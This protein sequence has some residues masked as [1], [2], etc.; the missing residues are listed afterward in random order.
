M[1][2]LTVGTRDDPLAER[3]PPASAE[4]E[5]SVLGCL[6]QDNSAIAVVS[7]LIDAR[8]FYQVDHREIFA[9][10][11]ALLQEGRP[12]DVVT[13]FERLQARGLGDECGGLQ[14][15]TDLTLCVPSARNAR[16]YAEIVAERF[17]ERALIAGCDEAMRISQDGSV[18]LADRVDSIA[19]AMARAEALRKGPARRVPLLGL[20]ALRAQSESVRWCVKHVLPAAS[21]GMLFG[22]SGTFKSFIA[23]D[24]ALHIVHGLPWMGRI[25]QT[26]PV[27]YIAAEGG[28][29]LWGRVDA[30][31]RARNLS[32]E[33]APLYV[34]P[35]AI[36]LTVDA[37]RV[38][39]AAQTVGVCPA[40]VVVDTLSQTYA[41]EENSANEMAAYLREIGLRFRALWGCTVLLVHHTGHQ[42]TERPRGSSAI[43]ANID[44]L[45]GVQR[46][47]KEMLATVSCQKQKDGDLFKDAT[48]SL[49]VVGLG[50]DA[51][52]DDVTSLVARQLGT[53]DEVQQ[54]R[55]AEQQAGRG[56]RNQILMG[57]VQN[58]MEERGL[59]KA[60]YEDLR[61]AG[62][63]DGDALKKAYYRARDTAIKAGLIELAE[64]Y[65]IDFRG[66]K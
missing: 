11:A 62:L 22:G 1:D 39:D 40:L 53:D 61:A 4:A 21:I 51:D 10:L 55:Q 28:A 13:V 36:D 60:F 47:E 3:P 48:F 15:L 20:D 29:G 6:L 35:A 56:G 38:V 30:W 46:D 64:G 49:A 27:L 43:R 52:G 19:A 58:G 66:K 26:G 8:S 7:D 54:A 17:A 16:S 24:A 50:K 42:A 65:I 31:H 59:R 63:T 45:V 37:W 5:Q 32:W 25:T 57:L 18:P 41:G 23:L 12:A 33:K 34:V 9:A 44:F 14:Y 2:A